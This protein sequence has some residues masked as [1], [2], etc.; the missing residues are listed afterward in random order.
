MTN[1]LYC[2]NTLDGNGIYTAKV[3]ETNGV[4]AGQFLKAV[5]TS[6]GSSGNTGNINDHLLVSL[7][8]ADGDEAL[9]CGI[10]AHD[11]DNNKMVGVITRGCFRF[12]TETIAYT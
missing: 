2:E 1:Y 4:D 5:G 6:L 12:M 11:A 3:S 10:A 9:L 7:M 8:D